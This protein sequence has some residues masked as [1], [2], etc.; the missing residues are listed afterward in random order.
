[1]RLYSGM[2]CGIAIL[3][4]L[5]LTGCFSAVS[6]GANAIY[7][8]Y[9]WENSVTDY[10]LNLRVQ[11]QFDRIAAFNNARVVVSVSGRI[12]L[13]TGQVATAALRRQAADIASNTSGVLRVY[14]CLTV[15]PPL[16]EK[17]M[18]EDS[19]LTTKI[20][21]RLLATRG[22]DPRSIKVVTENNVVYLMGILP[23]DQAD[24]AVAVAEDTDGVARI[25]KIFHYIIMP[26]I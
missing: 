19:W 12:V 7:N 23:R 24:V 3:S 20:K 14:N 5:L 10:T 16:S 6:A 18:L 9:S 8:R 22:I 15:G 4:M 2:K 17:Q 26:E 25:V 13:L 21:T 1:M 11:R